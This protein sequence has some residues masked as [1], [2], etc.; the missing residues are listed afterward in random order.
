MPGAEFFCKANSSGN[1]DAG[2]STEAKA[3][4]LNKIIEDIQCL[5]V[6]ATIGVVDFQLFDVF[7]NAPLANPFGNDVPSDFS[8]PFL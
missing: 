6:R 1:V 4:V 2:R 3:F 7:R 8:S 5:F